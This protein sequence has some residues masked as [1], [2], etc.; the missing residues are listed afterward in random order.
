MH[1]PAPLLAAVLLALLI[2]ALA[3][4]AA[5]TEPN[6]GTGRDCAARLGSSGVMVEGAALPANANAVGCLVSD[7]VR[8]AGVADPAAPDRRIL[9]PDKP[10][11]SCAMAER[12]ARFTADIAAPLAAGGLGERL[13][14][15]GTGPGHECRTRNRATGGKLSSHAQG[16]AVDIAT[17]TL[18]GGRRIVVEKPDGA[19]AARFLAGLRAAAC[20]AFN[21]VLGPGADAQHANH[22]HIDMEPRGRDGRSKFCQ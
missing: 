9:F 2:L 5:R 13:A 1:V 17:L 7:P 6:L 15:V 22:I 21:T 12:F 4:G 10:L 3:A 20:G 18:A 8:L 11:L 14:A 19:A 16:L